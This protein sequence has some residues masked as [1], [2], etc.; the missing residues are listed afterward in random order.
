MLDAM[1]RG[2]TNLFTK[3][4]LALLVVAFAIWGIGD[5]VRTSGDS[6]LATVGKTK[7]TPDEFRQAYQDEMQ[8]IARR[9][10]RKLTPEQAK[11]LGVESRA[12]SRLIGFA[13]LDLHAN[14]LDLAVSDN[15]V[16]T[17]VRGDPAFQEG[18]QFSPTRFRQLISQLGYVSEGQY[19]QARRRDIIREQLTETL[20]AGTRSADGPARGAASLPRGDARHRVSGA[21]L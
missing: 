10:G 15:I 12:L 14:A 13:S 5:V 17:V 11:I 1:R 6:A 8:S 21:R 18:G 9:L 7:I 4:L 16:V 20:G 3:L 19:I 2:V